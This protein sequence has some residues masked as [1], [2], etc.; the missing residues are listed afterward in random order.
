MKTRTDYSVAKWAKKLGVSRSGY[1]EHMHWREEREKAQKALENEIKRIFNESRGTYG[2]DRICGELRKSGKRTSYKKISEMMK[3]MGLSSVH[4]RHRSRSLTDSRKAR[5][6]DEKFPNL[7]RNKLFTQPRQAVCSDITYMRCGEGWEYLCSVK[8]IITGEILG[9]STGERLT[10]ELAVQAFMN[11]Q[12]R[13]D[14]GKG[15]IFHSDRGSQYTSNGFMGML[16]LYGI[17]QSFS[18]V[19]KP[20]DNAWAESFFATFKKE[21]TRFRHFSTREELRRVV[22][23]WI[24]VFYNNKRIQKR[25][26]YR[27][28][29]EFAAKLALR[30]A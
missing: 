17:K 7:V 25:L 1:Y 8:D 3:K 11:A 26:S 12:A 20:G 6:N 24:E 13:H 5:N 29:R 21:C 9:Y 23:E 19:G 16:R 27:S 30:A 14:F 2:P 10:K 15:I 22:F 18:R 4:N 28:P